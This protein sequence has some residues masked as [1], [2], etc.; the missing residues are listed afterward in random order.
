MRPAH[1]VKCSVVIPTYRRPKL[2][3][4]VLDALAAQTL[5]P[6]AFEVVVCDDAGDAATLHEI[7]QWR[8]TTPIA[9]T[10]VV[11][12]PARRG[13]AAMRN[14]GWRAARGEVIAFTDDDTIPDADWLRQGLLAFGDAIADAASGRVIVP[15]P[16]DP[17]DYE[18][19]AARLEEAGFVSA[20]CFCSRRVLESVGGF[21]TRFREAWR[22]D[23]DLFFRLVEA[24][25]D[26]V[27]AGDAVVVHPV[28]PAPWGV[29]LRAERKQ[30]FDAL[31]YKKH[32]E[33]YE[34]FIR[35]DRTLLYY[36]I[37]VSLTIAVGGG[38]AGLGWLAVAGT[39]GW[40][41]STALLIGRR[42]SETSRRASHVVEVV[43][44]SALVPWLSVF[45][46]IRGG[47]A[48][49]VAFW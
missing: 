34:Q 43:V 8:S 7:E 17:T 14:A 20:N 39:V 15:V 22:E 19:D 2:L 6:G 12:A 18:R 45:H 24:G 27:E 28:R 25:F 10:H 11:G 9:L 35:R 37:I 44:T 4:R 26:V 46:R 38:V 21:D 3:R 13:P 49:R 5:A 23:S 40:L 16:N 47:I 41:V 30:V 36:V 31:L 29:S 33:L 48:F 42:L 32:P 1:D